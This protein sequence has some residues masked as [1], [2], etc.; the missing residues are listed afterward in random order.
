M[1]SNNNTHTPFMSI[2]TFRLTSIEILSPVLCACMS[3]GPAVP[4]K[5]SHG[6]CRPSLC[7]ACRGPA[8][9]LQL[10]VEAQL[11]QCYYLCQCL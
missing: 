5:G 3:G 4:E 11:V 7:T 9:A 8:T 1:Q 2:I 6:K 10:L